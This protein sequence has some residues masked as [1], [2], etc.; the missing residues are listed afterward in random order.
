MVLKFDDI[1]E[2]DKDWI[3]FALNLE[4]PRSSSLSRSLYSDY[5]SNLNP[6]MN[7]FHKES[8]M[9]F[10]IRTFRTLPVY[11]KYRHLDDDNKDNNINSNISSDT[12]NS[13]NSNSSKNKNT[14]FNNNND[15]I[16]DDSVEVVNDVF[17]IR[18]PHQRIRRGRCV[19]VV[20]DVFIIDEDVV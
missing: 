1:D 8:I 17:I 4:V 7:D 3:W 10:C 6:R 15:I 9:K 18:N 20:N 16:L 13:I 2:K 5:F 11:E 19:E 12:N 14:I